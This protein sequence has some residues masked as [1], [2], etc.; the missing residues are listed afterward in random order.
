[1]KRAYLGQ[2]AW[3]QVERLEYKAQGQAPFHKVSR[4]VLF[5]D[6]HLLAQWRYFEVEPGGYSTLERHQHVHA[7]MVFRG[8][9]QCLVGHQVFEIGLGDLISV[10]PMTWHQF[11]A[12]AHEPLGFLCLV[13]AQRD[14]PQ[15]PSPTD[16]H[17]LRQHPTVA[18][19][20]KL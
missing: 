3:Q 18:A 7:V 19:V 2:G 12:A 9:G 8:S 17:E 11:Y 13:N 14:R 4:Q 16:L 1:M 5:E 6:P 20:I 15:L 10:P